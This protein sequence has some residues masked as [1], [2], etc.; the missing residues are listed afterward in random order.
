MEKGLHMTLRRKLVL[1]AAAG[2][3][4]VAFAGNAIAAGGNGKHLLSQVKAAAGPGAQGV[5]DDL[6]A[7]ATYLGVTDAAL[8]A[9]VQAGKTLAQVASATSGKTT[10]GL[11]AA[12]VTAETAEI[13]ARVTAGTITQAQADAQIATLTTRFTAFVNGTL[14]DHG[15]GGPGFPGGHGGGGSD[16]LAAAATYL[17][18]TQAALDADRQA[19]KTLAQVAAATTGKTTAGLI[20][21]L[22]THET[23]EIN[24]RVTAGRLTQ[25]QA[26]TE[27]ANLTTRFTA[28]VNGTKD[29]GGFH[30]F[31]G[32]RH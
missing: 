28:F 9:D 29:L 6:S 1:V 31:G 13:N 14:P 21:A 25:A 11:I 4:V 26:D 17:G 27:I 30:G 24:A 7:A 15:P 12:L 5:P 19:G 8:V 32:R 3:L 18:L 20:A 23:A 22:V 2:A 16:D 10:A